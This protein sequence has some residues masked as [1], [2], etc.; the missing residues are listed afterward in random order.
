M[1]ACVSP[2]YT[3]YEETLNTLKYAARARKIQNPAKRNI[4]ADNKSIAKVKRMIG[5]LKIEIAS[6]RSEIKHVKESE[7]QDDEL[8]LARSTNRR[9]S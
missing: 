4:K 2:A 9:N 6:L 7:S 1:L 3:H 8:N 5:E